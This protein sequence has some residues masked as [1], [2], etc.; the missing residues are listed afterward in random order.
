MAPRRLHML[1]AAAVHACLAERAASLTIGVT[2]D[3]TPS[4]F[5]KTLAR[6]DTAQFPW[7]VT[8]PAVGALI[9]VE[10]TG[11]ANTLLSKLI[12]EG[13]IDLSANEPGVYS[14]CFSYHPSAGWTGPV[15]PA[16][17]VVKVS[18]QETCAQPLLP[19]EATVHQLH[20]Q[21]LGKKVKVTEAR[22]R[23][24]LEGDDTQHGLLEGSLLRVAQGVAK[25]RAQ[26]QADLLLSDAATAA[27][28]VL[29]ERHLIWCG[30]LATV[31]VLLSL[32]QIFFSQKWISDQQP[33]RRFTM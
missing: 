14:F 30:L 7:R 26:Q 12:A 19:I 32:F 1:A 27:R 23:R 20:L 21:R 31:V 16:V 24:D 10:V 6:F 13:T 29:V 5:S 25:I 18:F 33:D 9:N 2:S 22:D 28:A 17:D 4:C 3:G 11:P 15:D 8:E